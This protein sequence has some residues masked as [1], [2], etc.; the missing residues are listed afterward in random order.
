[1]GRHGAQGGLRHDRHAAVG[2]R[3]RR[4]RLRGDDVQRHDFAQ[5]G[6]STA[7]RWAVTFRPPGRKGAGL[8]SA[9][10]AM[11]TAPISTA[12]RLSRAGWMRR[13]R[14]TRK[15]TMWFGPGIASRGRTTSCRLR[16]YRECERGDLHECDRR[17]V[18]AAIGRIRDSTRVT[19]VLL[20][21]GDRNPDAALDDVR[22]QVLR[23]ET[24]CSSA[25]GN[26]G[27]R[28]YLADLVHAV[29]RLLKEPL[30]HFVVL[31][32]LRCSAST[33]FLARSNPKKG[34]KSS[35]L[36]RRSPICNSSLPGPGSVT[37][38]RRS[39]TRTSVSS[40]RDEVYYRE[41]KALELDGD[42]IVIRRRIRQK[43]EF[44][45]EDTAAAKP[46]DGELNAYLASHQTQ[47]RNEDTVTFHHVFLS[48][49]REEA[50]EPRGEEIG[51]KLARQGGHERSASATPF[52][53][54]TVFARFS[55][56]TRFGPS[57]KI[58]P[59]GS[60]V[61]RW[62]A[63]KDPFRRAT[64]CTSYL[65]TGARRELCRRSMQSA[66][67]LSGNGQTRAAPRTLKS[68][69]AALRRRYDIAIETP[70]A[71]RARRKPT[72]LRERYQ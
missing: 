61:C 19:R 66:R 62:A 67:P 36:P 13:A 2:P 56:A 29:T 71:R 1:M 49:A 12:S 54:A 34:R 64:A 23:D 59:R 27:P 26:S 50:L 39:S 8:C 45:A 17:A 47:F 51:A 9:R 60:L 3:L 4:L 52:C 20:R 43:M 31:G 25:D 5:H 55:R 15:S 40:I 58:L 10:C 48:S 18:L 32:M 69:I 21:A 63:G 14:R 44:L 41:G 72:K 35:F 70:R 16:Q 24:A 33:A 37:R 46:T 38:R 53:L 68:F 7:C 22:R 30:L 42:D 6:Y 65:S 28:V 11:P 57:A